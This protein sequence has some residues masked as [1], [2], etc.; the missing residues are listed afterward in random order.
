MRA[1]RGILSVVL[2]LGFGFALVACGDDGGD[3]TS[4]TTSASTT[5]GAS[6]E[7]LSLASCAEAEYGGD[8]EPEGLIVS[9]LPMQGDSAERSNQQVEAIR[10]VLADNEW[11]AGDVPVAFQA[12]DDSIAKTG[13]WDEATCEENAQGYAADDRVLAVIGTYNSGCAAIEI[14]ILGEAGVAMVSPGN[15][16]VC[17][18]EPSPNCEDGQPDSLYPA[19]RNYARVIPNDAFQGAGL[20]TYVQE[21]GAIRPFVAYAADDPTSTGQAQNFRGAAEE[22]GLELSGFETWDPEAKDYEDLFTQA[23]KAGADAV[24]LAGLTEQNGAQVIADKV[25]YA[26]P[27]SEV[28]LLAFDGFAQQST[29]DEAG[30]DSEGM[31]ATVPGLAPGEL[32]PAGADLVAQLEENL[33]GAPVEQFAPYAGQAAAVVLDAIEAGGADREAI[34]EAVFETSVSDGI[35]G[36]F[37]IEPSG[38]PSVG[39]ITVLEAGASF[40]P[41]ETVEPEEAAVA[42]ARG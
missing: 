15:T 27:N 39:P 14:P 5:T 41:T 3:S 38:D 2:V 42:A 7:G 21:L 35:V 28:P 24:V 10:A 23:E 40:E 13:L 17:L 4:T 33:D 36:S 20:A 12:C 31:F 30:S 1:I 9:D 8:A 11:M 29:I 6:A 16:A 19:T 25:K 26:G 18:T 22:L 37:D 32:P 34:V